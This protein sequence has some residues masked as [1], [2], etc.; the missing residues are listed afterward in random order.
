MEY[1]VGDIIE[2]TYGIGEITAILSSPTGP[3]IQTFLVNIHTWTYGTV[4]WARP[5]Y[6]PVIRK[7]DIKRKLSKKRYAQLQLENL[8]LNG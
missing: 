4:H 6:Q 2:C 3:P 8:L 7:F 5:N 1:Q